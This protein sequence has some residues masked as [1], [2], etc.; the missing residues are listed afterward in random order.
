M[1]MWDK[2]NLTMLPPNGKLFV[3]MFTALMTAVFLWAGALATIESGIFG[4]DEDEQAAVQAYDYQ[5]D[6]E[7]IMADS[8][9]VTAP[10]WADSGQEEPIDSNDLA[11]FTPAQPTK[12]KWDT[13]IENFKLGHVHLNGHTALYFALGLIFFFSTSSDKTKKLV[14]IVFGVAILV[15]AIGLAGMDSCIYGRILVFVGGPPLLA[16]ILFM[17][18]RIFKDL[19]K[20][21]A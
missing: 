12:S 15:H 3:G 4:N 18:Y 11:D 19:R 20:K 6:M 8:E 16:S 1:A 13:F 9:A 5:A 14:Y 2:F 21:P 7:T 10:N 17:V